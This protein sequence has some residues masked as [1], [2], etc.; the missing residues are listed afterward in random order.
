MFLS[1][2][3]TS[4]FFNSVTLPSLFLIPFYFY[5]TFRST[6]RD[7]RSS[8][9]YH[10]RDRN[11]GRRLDDSRDSRDRIRRDEEDRRSDRGW[12]RKERDRDSRD[13]P[14]APEIG[15]IYNGR[16]ISIQPFGAFIQVSRIFFVFSQVILLE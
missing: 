1:Y 2:K 16:V 3:L 5:F 4:F 8:R 15:R 10:D 14:D 11:R 12:K 6:S 13:L 9:K 7:V